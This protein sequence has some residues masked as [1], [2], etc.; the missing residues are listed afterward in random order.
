MIDGAVTMVLVG[1]AL[2]AAPPTHALLLRIR[3]RPNAAEVQRALSFTPLPPR[4]RALE[5]LM[6]S[7]DTALQRD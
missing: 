3:R 4:D 2:Q 1:A 7:A 5:Q 6:A